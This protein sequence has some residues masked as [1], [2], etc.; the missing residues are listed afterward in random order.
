MPKAF[1]NG[2]NI[3]Y[4]QTGRGPDLVLIHGIASNLGQWQL[5]TLPGLVEHFRLTMY[6]LR[7]HGYSDM[8]ARGYTPEHMLGDF[9]ALMDHLDIA[10]CSIVGHSYGG[11]VALGYAVRHPARVHK[12]IIADT[13]VPAVEPRD[14]RDAV[15]VGWRESLRQGGID[16]PEDK[17]EDVGYLIEQTLKLRGRSWR[18]MG[19]R[20]AI[21]RLKRFT[22][23]TSFAK[24]YRQVSSL[25]LDMIRQIEAPVLLI[26]GDRSPLTASLQALRANLPNCRTA[27]VADGGHFYPLQHPETFVRHIKG[28][29]EV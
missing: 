5:G 23:A 4:I 15:L 19:A 17:A 1:V 16:V 2:L 20:R 14:G 10:R 3:H 7:G 9:S 8:P 12:L 27:I 18:G 25:T 28:F 11:L 21:A 26:Y 22:T 13:G 6:D 24:E 29:L